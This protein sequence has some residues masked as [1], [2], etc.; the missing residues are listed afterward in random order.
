MVGLELGEEAVESDAH[1]GHLCGGSVHVV[2]GSNQREAGSPL[3]LLYT[4]AL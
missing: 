1:K 2:P 3:S 4:C